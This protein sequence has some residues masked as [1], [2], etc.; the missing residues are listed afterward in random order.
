MAGALERLFRELT[1]GGALTEAEAGHM[2]RFLPPAPASPPVGPRRYYDSRSGELVEADQSP[3]QDWWR[4]GAP[5]SSL[6]NED[7]EPTIRVPDDVLGLP[8]D[9]RIPEIERYRIAQHEDVLPGESLRLGD[10]WGATPGVSGLQR[11]FREGR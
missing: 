7:D 4:I 3:G 9:A 8:I 11:L 6:E 10:V 2:K 1:G 5:S